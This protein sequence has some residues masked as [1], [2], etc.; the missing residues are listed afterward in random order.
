MGL[1]M[2][3][4]L[5]AA[6]ANVKARRDAVGTPLHLAAWFGHADVATLLLNGGMSAHVSHIEQRTLAQLASALQGPMSMHQRS[7]IGRRFTRR[8]SMATRRLPR[9]C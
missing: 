8:P 4:W 9:C 3:P 2:P 5:R 7:A 6:G 1:I